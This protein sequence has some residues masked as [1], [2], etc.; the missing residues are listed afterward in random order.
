MSITRLSL[1]SNWIGDSS[2]RGAFRLWFGWPSGRPFEFVDFGRVLAASD[3]D[4][5]QVLGCN[6]HDEFARGADIAQ[7]VLLAPVDDSLAEQ[8]GG[9]LH[10]A[11][12]KLNGARLG[13]L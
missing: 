3:S 12:K 2:T 10:T 8:R 4:F 11:L 1:H 9:S 6:V 5:H 13:T 7:R